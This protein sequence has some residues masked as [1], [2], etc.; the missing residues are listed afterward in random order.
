MPP[1]LRDIA[2]RLKDVGIVLKKPNRGSHWKFVRERDR[3]P[4]PV[5]AHNGERSEI[6]KAYLRA[7]VRTFELDEDFF[8][9]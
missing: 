2:S 4:Y 8:T 1:R 3:K 7:L 5:P 9:R 6:S